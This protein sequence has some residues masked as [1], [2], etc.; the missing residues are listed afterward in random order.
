MTTAP[1]F[2][3]SKAREPR[4]SN[5]TRT[6]AVPVSRTPIR[7]AWESALS[8]YELAAMSRGLSPRSIAN[9]R[10]SVTGLARWLESE[11]GVTAPDQVTRQHM[12][13]AMKRAY[14][15]REVSGARTYFNDQKA[16]WDAWS[17]EEELPSPF[18]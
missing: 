14:N 4:R 7:E 10:S 17:A 11:H 5:Q 15:E 16:F 2:S 18:T 3:A 12:M 8:T 13:L 6:A 1:S 9:R